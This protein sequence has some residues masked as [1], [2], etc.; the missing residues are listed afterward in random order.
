METQLRFL[1]THVRWGHQRRYQEWFARK[2][3]CRP[4]SEIVICDIVRF[5]CCAHHPPNEIIQ[6]EVISRW[7]I[8][9]WLLKSC[10]K[11]HVEA[12]TKLALFYDWLFFDERTDNI[13]NIEPGILLMVNSIPKYIDM[14]HTLLEFLLLLVDN[15]DVV[16]KDLIIQ[17]VSTAF[18]VLVKKG[19]VRSLEALTS[20]S[21]LSP[22]LKERLACIFSDSKSK[23]LEQKQAASLPHCS[24][25]PLNL[26]SPSDAESQKSL[27]TGVKTLNRPRENLSLT[28]TVDASSVQ[29]LNLPSP[30]SQ[31]TLLTYVRTLKRPRESLS[32]TTTLDASSVQP[33]NLPSPSDA[34]GQ[35]LLLKSVR[36]LKR[37]PKE[38]VSLTT[39][40]DASFPVLDNPLASSSPPVITNR[41][42]VSIIEELVQTLG[43]NVK[44]SN[45]MG[46]QTLGEILFLFANLGNDSPETAVAGDS[47][48]HP[49]VLASRITE[50]FKSNGY[51]MFVPLKYPQEF[52]CD[53]EIQSATALITCTFIFSQQKRIQEMILFWSR[54]GYPVGPRLLSYAS[55]LFYEAH[56]MS[57]L[58]NSMDEEC[59]VKRSNSDMS[60]LKHHVDRYISFLSSQEKDSFE[61]GV[62][63]SKLD[64]KLVVDL[65]EGA[66][67]SYRSFLALI[68]ISHREEDTSLSKLLFSDLLSCC[69]WE[70]KRL[71]SIFCSIFS[72]LSDLCTSEEEFIRLI[73]EKLDHVDL[74]TL[75][76]D[77]CLKRF[78]MFGE[79]TKM[80]SHLIKC[81]LNWGFLEQ[82]KFW[83]LM[84][85]EL[86]VSKVQVE[87]VVM[88]CIVIF[89]PNVHSIATGGFFALCSRCRPTPE[90][91]GTM[92]SLPDNTFGDFAAAVLAN[93][94]VS[95]GSL[96][97]NSIAEC[98]EKLHNRDTDSLLSNSAGVRINN[99]TILEFLEAFYRLLKWIHYPICLY[100]LL[101]AVES[102]LIE[103]LRI[104][105]YCLTIDNDPQL[106][107]TRMKKKSTVTFL[108]IVELTLEPLTAILI[109]LEMMTQSLDVE[110][111]NV[112][113]SKD[114]AA[115]TSCCTFLIP[116]DCQDMIGKSSSAGIGSH[117]SIIVVISNRNII[118]EQLLPCTMGCGTVAQHTVADIIDF[119]RQPKLENSKSTLSDS[120]VKLMRVE[121]SVPP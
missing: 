39:S 104:L 69:G 61:V 9:G 24:V 103:M 99:S 33:L 12:N 21:L 5:I 10:R 101:L 50:A 106:I 28:T 43:E 57:C 117:L 40:V 56:V 42:P 47:V 80:M 116:A 13:M 30:S 6:S 67:A 86:A 17:G 62:S 112:D 22:L 34:E 95:N 81:S 32:L 27:L 45:K 48:L 108:T 85:L 11:N 16:R 96:L 52:N 55:R 77:I 97:F 107:G 82:Q 26:S 83:A 109:E 20:C 78:S 29:P 100:L 1:L 37:R 46:L 75:Q 88:D 59:S 18:R 58:R 63:A 8:I 38:I 7:A 3:F 76:F 84:A 105:R 74:V 41:T 36:T 51:E 31:K 4:E 91:V 49:E 71:K 79:D 2:F 54:N 98:L 64:A 73:V 66:F 90:L 53:D 19:V 92:I 110:V 23:A 68:N 119:V 115:G 72:Y 35:K 15:Y 87:K 102:M 65:V 14:T 94:V 113:L 118:V 114:N 121:N 111:L 44:K 60:L 120:W 25:Q 70:T 93:W 89:D